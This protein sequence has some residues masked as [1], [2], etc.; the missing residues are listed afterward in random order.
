MNCSLLL[1]YRIDVIVEC[2]LSSSYTFTT[3]I[4]KA[5]DCMH[6]KKKI[7]QKDI[8]IVLLL[9][10]LER[11]SYTYLLT[12]RVTNH[13]YRANTQSIDKEGQGSSMRKC[14]CKPDGKAKKAIVYRLCQLLG[15]KQ[16]YESVTAIQV[17]TG[18]LTN[19]GRINWN[20]KLSLSR[21]CLFWN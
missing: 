19:A 20:T 15:Q 18:C 14:S 3:N 1:C 8:S 9:F 7:C 2:I 21:A 4:H 5:L 10:E 12:D 11:L 13:V 16:V 6:G 17:I